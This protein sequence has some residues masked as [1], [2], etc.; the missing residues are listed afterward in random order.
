[1]ALWRF[2]F[3]VTPGNAFRFFDEYHSRI[4]RPRTAP[5][6]IYREPTMCLR[7]H[8]L[9]P[10]PSGKGSPLRLDVCGLDERP[11]LVGRER[12]FPKSRVRGVEGDPGDLASWDLIE[13]SAIY[14][15]GRTD[16]T[17]D[18]SRISCASMTA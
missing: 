12:M 7:T 9:A 5:R 1:M 2:V 11:V 13:H 3:L 16:V 17:Q 4:N 6:Y 8:L 14:Q 10:R 15:A 18:T